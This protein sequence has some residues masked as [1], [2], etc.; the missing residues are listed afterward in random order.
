[1]VPQQRATRR[2]PASLTSIC[3]SYGHLHRRTAQARPRGGVGPQVRMVPSNNVAPV[4]SP[5]AT[6]TVT[7][8]VVD[9]NSPPGTNVGKP[10]KASD[11][12]G[13]VL[14][15]TLAG[16]DGADYSIDSCTGQITVVQ[17]HGPHWTGL[18]RER[19]RDSHGH[20]PVW[21]HALVKSK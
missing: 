3:E 5:A 2:F 18:Q 10:V 8:R 12:A 19:Q 21:F 1:M 20:R 6:D 14:T 17:G 15:Y 9:E 16:T 4:D 13:D 7:T 11:T